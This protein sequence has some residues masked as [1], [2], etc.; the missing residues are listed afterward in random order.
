MESEMKRIL[1]A[2]ALV[3]AI[4]SPALAQ[5]YDPDLGSGNLDAAAYASDSHAQANNRTHPV[6]H[7]TVRRASPSEAYAQVPQAAAPRDPAPKRG[8]TSGKLV[9]ASAAWLISRCH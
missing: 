8:D 6:R 2:A 7:R 1:V 3:S 4:A 5:S 9:A